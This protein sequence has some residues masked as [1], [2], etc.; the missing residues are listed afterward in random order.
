MEI[1]P[2]TSTQRTWARCPPPVR[3]QDHSENR[4]AVRFDAIPAPEVRARLKAHGF[5]WSPT[6]G[7]WVRMLNMS[8]WYAARYAMGVSEGNG[9]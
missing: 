2:L 6:R 7:A 5:R 4:L 9:R 3:R 1:P 8:A